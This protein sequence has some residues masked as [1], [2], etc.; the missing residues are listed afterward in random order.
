MAESKG[1]AE[2][3]KAKFR[4]ALDKKNSN[5]H[6]SAEGVERDGSEKSHGADGPTSAREFRRK[7]V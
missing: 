3:M 6:A 4:E 5:K 2:D 1:N 7:S